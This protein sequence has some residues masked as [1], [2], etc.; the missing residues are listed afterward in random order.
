MTRLKLLL[1]LLCITA[2]AF[3]QTTWQPKNLRLPTRWSKEVSPDNALKAY[4]RPQMMRTEWTNLNG[5]WDFAITDTSVRI[6]PAHVDGQILVPYPLESALSGVQKTLKPNQYLWYKKTIQ[7]KPQRGKKTLLHFGAVDNEAA[8]FVDGKKVGTHKGGYTA[9]TL[10]ITTALKNGDN[11]I[12]VKVYDATDQ[13][14]WPHGKQVSSPANIYY[15]PSSGIWQTVWLE[16]VPDV[17]IH[18]LKL[19]PD[20]DNKELNVTVDAPKGYTVR[21]TA[22]DNRNP[23][24]VIQG[25][26]NTAITLPLFNPKLWSPDQPFLYDLKVEL[27]KGSKVIDEVSSYFGMRKV[28][29]DKDDKGF[30]RIFLNNRYVYNLGVL[31]QGFWPDGLYT[32]PTDEALKF[33]IV[34]IKAMGFNTI[35]KHIKVEPARWYYHADQLGMLVWQDFVNPQQSLPEGAKAAFETQLNETMDQLHNHSCITTWVL[36]NERWGAFDQQRLTETIKRKD[37][38]RLLNAH[39]GELLWVNEQLRAPA[40][41]PWASSD[42]ADVHAYPDPMNAPAKAGRVQILGEFGGIGV[43]IPYHQW[44][45]NKSWGYVQVTPAQ[46]Q[47]K[48]AV[49]NEHLQ[50]LEREGLAGSIYTQPYDV[51]GEEN[52]LM[53]YDREVIKIPLDSL[54]KIHAHLVHDNN[55]I[56]RIEIANADLTDPGQHYAEQL[57]RYIDGERDAA[58]LKKLSMLA[59]QVG[60]KNGVRRIGNDYVASLDGRELSAEELKMVSEFTAST[61]D[62]GYQLIKANEAAFKQSLGERPYTVKM[63]NLIYNG[64]MQELLDNKRSPDWSAI[65]ARVKPFGAPGE[66]ILLRAKTVHYFNAQDWMNYTPV[67]QAYLEKYG[68]NLSEN[69]RKMFTDALANGK[70]PTK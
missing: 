23:V 70:V 41:N 29:V 47:G 69:E 13:G 51:E 30:Y 64:E 27:L 52:G 36:F 21:L 33:D 6:L 18:E 1:A 9:F 40:D 15:T 43:F 19:T 67:A 49:M 35:R 59:A 54:R 16:T 44:L 22:L 68:A 60:D 31:D 48:Y 14:V 39:S 25:K 32:A 65:E 10:D 42:I 63:M 5:L 12:V 37:P 7:H 61:R 24:S 50:L 17:Y 28:S 11:V 20:V 55:N 53:T 26:T 4:P 38:S 66:E 45:S 3:T 62:A 34:A 46:L 56:P 8:V 57:Q 2:T 58:F